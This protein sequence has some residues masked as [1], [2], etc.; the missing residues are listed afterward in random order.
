LS[1]EDDVDRYEPHEIEAK[2]QRVWDEA[3]AFTVPNP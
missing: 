3:G 1:L 2:W